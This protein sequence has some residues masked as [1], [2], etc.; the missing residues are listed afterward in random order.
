MSVVDGN[1]SNINLY[2]VKTS[3][4]SR[5]EEVDE[6]WLQRRA[7]DEKSSDRL[8]RKRALTDKNVVIAD[9]KGE[10]RVERKRSRGVQIDLDNKDRVIDALQ[11][12][13]DNMAGK[14]S[15][16]L[17][18]KAN[19]ANAVTSN[20]LIM[21]VV[22]QV[23]IFSK[24]AHR[25][26]LLLRREAFVNK[27][28]IEKLEKLLQ[29]KKE[30]INDL[31]TDLR[32]LLSERKAWDIE[33][34]KM[35]RLRSE[36]V[37]LRRDNDRLLLELD[38]LDQRDSKCVA[39]GRGRFCTGF[40]QLTLRLFRLRLSNKQAQEVIE[41][42]IHEMK[43]ERHKAP[44]TPTLSKIRSD[45]HPICDVLAAI[46]LCRAV[47]WLQLGR[48]GTTVDKDTTSVSVAV[49]HGDGKLEKATLS[50][51]L[52][53]EDKSA[54]SAY[55]GIIS[56]VE[57]IKRRCIMFLKELG[58]DVAAR[59]PDPEGLRFS[60]MRSSSVMSD[61][62][63]GALNTSSLLADFIASSV[64]D[65]MVRR[66]ED[67]D[68]MS[69]D[70]RKELSEATQT[71]C[72]AHIRRICADRG[73]EAENRW[74]DDRYRTPEDW[75]KDV[76]LIGLMKTD[77]DSLIHSIQKCVW[78]SELGAGYAKL[79]DFQSFL[80]GNELRC[81]SMGSRK[82]GNRMDKSMENGLKLAVDY[83]KVRLYMTTLFFF[84]CG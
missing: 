51:S 60:K 55:V 11:E 43:V 40:K 81:E 57:R 74:M 67:L 66:G 73:V 4:E 62:N 75:S 36:N 56:L 63:S 19:E 28:K 29:A 18:F 41:E 72:F 5:A 69:E 32:E 25:E 15:D 16:L 42:T 1:G 79:Q 71:R 64:E 52:L 47:R 17:S 27:Q 23:S 83:K 53:C 70:E 78:D 38:E 21:H 48:D 20:C 80:H 8:S 31:T 39:D 49:Q 34:K 46:K 30:E 82:T 44:S 68:E 65:F 35:D 37:A 84:S 9:L 58:Q 7:S 12:Q 61:N 50:S 13:S 24:S 26:N 10:L 22:D 59:R 76:R 45:L 14:A 54:Q 3:L 2:T 77:L 33:M 6:A